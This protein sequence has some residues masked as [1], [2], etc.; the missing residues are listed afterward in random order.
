MFSESDAKN[1]A[2]YCTVVYKN[3]WESLRKE[4]IK[5]HRSVTLFFKY[6]HFSSQ[7]D[8]TP[9]QKRQQHSVNQLRDTWVFS[10]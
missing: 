1:L 10:L 6:Y 7:A 3:Q 9:L 8:K 4:K 2:E 5:S